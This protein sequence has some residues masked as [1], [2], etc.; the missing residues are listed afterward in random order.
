MRE[1]ICDAEDEEQTQEQAE[2]LHSYDRLPDLGEEWWQAV[3]EAPIP[4]TLDDWRPD[5]KANEAQWR[6]S[7]ERVRAVNRLRRSWA[8]LS[9]LNGLA[10]GGVK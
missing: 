4:V 7:L 2:E 5:A 6:A 1:H 8:N 9:A 3:L 10:V